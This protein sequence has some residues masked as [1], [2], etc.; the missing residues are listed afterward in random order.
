[1]QIEQAPGVAHNAKGE[2]II[3]AETVV[4]A[5]LRASDVFGRWGGEEFVLV[6]PNMPLSAAAERADERFRGH[7]DGTP[8][9]TTAHR[10]GNHRDGVRW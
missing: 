7:R 9:Q 1:M 6:L 5:N 4:A 3:S 10:G 8:P 2:P